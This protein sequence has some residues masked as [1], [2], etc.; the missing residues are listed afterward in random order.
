[1]RHFSQWKPGLESSVLIHQNISRRRRS[2]FWTSGNDIAREGDWVWAGT[3]ARSVSPGV[4]LE[5]PYN[6]LEENCLVWSVS[7]ARQGV[8][9]SACC[10]NI[11][12][13]CEL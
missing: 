11:G 8:V 9:S 6:S 13:I 5:S 3:R 10:N 12:Y 7:Q 2:E 1:M 4:W